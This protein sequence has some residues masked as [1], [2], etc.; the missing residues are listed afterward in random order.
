MRQA[1]AIVALIVAIGTAHAQDADTIR[2]DGKTFR[3]DGIDAPE[4][5]QTCLDAEGA[6]YPCGQAAAQ[7]LAKLVGEKPAH[8]EDRGEDTRYQNRRIGLCHAASGTEINR[9]LV[10][11]GWA[12]NFEPY[13]KGRFKADED[14]ARAGRLGM[15]KGCFVAP[16]D[17]RRWNK[18]AAELL[19]P[20][21]PADARDKLFPD[22]P[23]MPPGCEIKGK[24]SLRAWPYRGIYHEPGCGSYRRTTK[25]DRWFCSEEDAWAAQFRRSFTC[26][27]P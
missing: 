14:D 25:P 24:Y 10:Q 20:S 5:D 17:F 1:F 23:R 12:V 13:A 19:G 8:C 11:Q 4:F 27:L 15:W 2:F 26:W 18:K 21:C 6:I 7:A 3:L 9:W 16:R 22:D